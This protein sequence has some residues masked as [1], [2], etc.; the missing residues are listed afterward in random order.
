[1]IFP[2]RP[3]VRTTLKGSPEGTVTL[4]RGG[5]YADAADR[6]PNTVSL[7]PKIL[8]LGAPGVIDNVGHHDS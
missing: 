1:M 3:R 7:S 2:P 4:F 6:Y 5:G 8:S